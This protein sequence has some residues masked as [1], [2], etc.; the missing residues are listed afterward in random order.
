LPGKEWFLD[1][2]PELEDGRGQ[3]V[4]AVGSLRSVM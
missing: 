3:L 1:E 2:F 4:F